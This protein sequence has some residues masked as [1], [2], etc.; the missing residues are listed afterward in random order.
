MAENENLRDWG[1]DPDIRK[2]IRNLELKL[3]G[4]VDS[5][6]SGL[7]LEDEEEGD[8]VEPMRPID[9][10]NAYPCEFRHTH[11]P[12][13]PELWPQR[14]LLLRPTPNTNTRVIGVRYAS[15]S[16]DSYTPLPGAKMC[17]GCTLPINNGK[18]QP[19]KTLVVDFET[20]LFMGTAMI[21]IQD[22]KPVSVGGAI[23]EPTEEGY[24]DGK[25]RTFQAVVRG[26]FLEPGI[27]MSE[28]ITGQIFNKPAGSLPPRLVLAG[29]VKVISHLAPQ[30]QAEFHGECPRFLSP[31]VSTAQSAHAKAS[32]EPAAK[33]QG[34]DATIEI[35]FEEPPTSSPESLLQVLPDASDYKKS[36]ESHA[37][38]AK[39]RKKA[40]DKSYAKKK[41]EPTFDTTTE[42]TFEFYQHLLDFNSETLSVDMGRPVGKHGLAKMLNGQPIKFMA[43]QQKVEDDGKKKKKTKKS[44]FDEMDWLWSFDI[45]HESLF[46]IASDAK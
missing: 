39:A 24:F 22:C 8:V 19:G 41:K 6:S 34:A 3:M 46:K 40:F 32:D 9:D 27:P 37:S 25:K 26:K 7:K 1:D 36:P 35:A 15:D 20:N 23:P 43:A 29:A 38:R 30:L 31:L 12:P 44:A 18:E 14:P 4:M 33:Y 21:R 5:M 28:C 10:G 11:L 2:S 16:S 45:W 13:E 17:M 42:Y